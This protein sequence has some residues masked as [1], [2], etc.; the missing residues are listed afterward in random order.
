MFLYSDIMV[1]CYGLYFVKILIINTNFNK[2]C[3]ITL[4]I[5]IT[6]YLF[7][8]NTKFNFYHFYYFFYYF[9]IIFAITF[10]IIL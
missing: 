2:I 3:N 10:I 5:Y 9:E 4:F 1:Q 7:T 6:K 8:R